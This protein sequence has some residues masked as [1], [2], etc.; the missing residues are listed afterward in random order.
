MIGWDT[1]RTCGIMMMYPSPFCYKTPPLKVV[2]RTSLSLPSTNEP[3]IS[4]NVRVNDPINNL[5]TLTL[6]QK[7]PGLRQALILAGCL[8]IPPLAICPCK[9]TCHHLYRFHLRSLS[10]NGCFSSWVSAVRPWR[11]VSKR[12]AK[13][14]C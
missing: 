2:A 9:V 14:L 10:G 1:V 13:V 3:K 7:Q 12:L 4:V 6:V 11:P 5:V 8:P